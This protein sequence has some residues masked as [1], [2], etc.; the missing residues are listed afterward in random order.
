ML[1]SKHQAYE[2][3]AITCPPAPP[4]CDGDMDKIVLMNPLVSWT[5]RAICWFWLYCLFSA[6]DGRKTPGIPVELKTDIVLSIQICFE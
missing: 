1:F 6:R 5:P 2:S 4:M 3:V